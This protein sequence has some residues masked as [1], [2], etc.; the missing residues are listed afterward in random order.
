[1]VGLSRSAAAWL[2]VA[3]KSHGTE[4]LMEYAQISGS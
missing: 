1:M 2:M 4:E 3:G